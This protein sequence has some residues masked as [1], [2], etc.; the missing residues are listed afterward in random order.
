MVR[1]GSAKKV[2]INNLVRVS[3]VDFK[4]SNVLYNNLID[5]I[6]QY[7]RLCMISYDACKYFNKRAWL[8]AGKNYMMK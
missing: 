8:L 2:E 5:L 6:E 1:I 3:D 4:Y 7:Y